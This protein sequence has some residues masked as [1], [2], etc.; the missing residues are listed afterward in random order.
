MK[1]VN[2]YSEH[3]HKKEST[4]NWKAKRNN[5]FQQKKK[6]FVPNRNSKNNNTRNFPSKNFQGNKSNSQTNP[7]NQRNKESANNHSNC[8]K[9]FEQKKPIKCWECN[10]PHYA[11][12]FPNRKKTISNIHTI[13]EEMNVGDLAEKMARINVALENRQ[14]YYQNSMVELEGKINQI[15]ISILIDP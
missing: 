11:S 14:T 4:T 9:N 6:E 5:N 8:T 10:G 7:N 2:F 13:Q 3:N 12:I 1:K 15:H